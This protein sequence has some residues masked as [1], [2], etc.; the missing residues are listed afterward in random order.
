MRSARQLTSR[1]PTEAPTRCPPDAV[2]TTIDELACTV[3][4]TTCRA[5]PDR[6]T[7]R[8]RQLRRAPA[9][10]PAAR[11]TPRRHRPDDPANRPPPLTIDR[12]LGCAGVRPERRP[13]IMFDPL[14]GSQA[15]E[16][17]TQRQLSRAGRWWGNNPPERTQHHLPASRRHRRPE[18]RV[19]RVEFGAEGSHFGARERAQVVSSPIRG[20]CRRTRFARLGS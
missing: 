14:S 11:G 20:R 15:A 3:D 9:L 2:T 6:A 13:L 16:S 19:L 1:G 8:N 7:P 10:Q 17:G 18:V 12:A 5:R 4:R